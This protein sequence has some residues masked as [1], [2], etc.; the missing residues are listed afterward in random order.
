MRIFTWLT[1]PFRNRR[2]TPILKGLKSTASLL[3]RVG[4]RAWAFGRRAFAFLLPWALAIVGPLMIARWIL[5][6][7][8]SKVIASAAGLLLMA[9]IAWRLELGII[10]VIAVAASVIYPGVVPKPITFGGQGLGFTELLV[11][12]MAVMSFAKCCVERRFHFFKS[13]L[14]FPMILF[15][16]TAIMSIVVSYVRYMENPFGPW[17]VKEVY[18][19]TRPVF[20]YL[21]F[22]IVA[23]GL[24]SEKQI[25]RILR[26]SI[27][28]A[29]IVSIL[30]V[31]QYFA[32]KQV[33]LFYG[34]TPVKGMTFVKGLGPEEEEVT[35]SLP[36]GLA[37]IL[38]FF[39]VCVAKAAS[40]DFRR[41]VFS[42]ISAVIIGM[43]I[44]F[45]FTRNYWM[46][47]AVALTI[48]FILSRDYGRRR[49]AGLIPA[50]VASAILGSILIGHL[51]PGK[52]GREFLPALERRFMSIFQGG[53]RTNVALEDRRHENEMAL[54]RIKQ[55]PVFG[56]GAGMPILYKAK[57]YPQPY[58]T[59]FYPVVIIHNSYLQLWAT[60][61]I[62]G[63]ISFAWLS[64]AFLI[65]SLKL[66]YRLRDPTWKAVSLAFFAG[67]IGF[68]IRATVTMAV[69]H[70]VHNIVMVALMFGTI[71][72]LWLYHQDEIQE[73][74]QEKPLTYQLRP[75]IHMPA[76]RV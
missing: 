21:L 68:L 8:A 40:E 66:Y 11:F 3:L 73:Q 10:L 4:R 39:L 9:I 14:T 18:N 30:M 49:L 31:I 64:I 42:V 29:A 70:E 23:F 61:G 15:G 54:L 65:R 71:E 33:T 44:V 6:V 41:A 43:G 50:A 5:D 1:T 16:I 59:L 48:I 19:S 2:L 36:P 25:E 57:L 60:Y 7:Q 20:H 55:S 47:T 34:G 53:Y 28:I 46:A 37:P 75:E 63:I 35:R 58:G 24:R 56:V 22:F 38:I 67:Y 12:A 17:P 52:A 27:W 13:P 74:E 45:M 69:V 26:A 76:A 32:G 51:A 62:L 72:Y